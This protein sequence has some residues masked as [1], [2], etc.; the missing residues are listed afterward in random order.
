MLF[1]DVPV[2]TDGYKSITANIISAERWVHGYKKADF[3]L[4]SLA[5]IR[6]I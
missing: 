4:I 5:T 2:R 3:H 6:L 1:A